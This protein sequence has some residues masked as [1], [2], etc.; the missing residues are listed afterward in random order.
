MSELYWSCSETLEQ[1]SESFR[2]FPS[3]SHCYAGNL[4]VYGQRCN[5]LCDV[6]SHWWS[7]PCSQCLSCFSGECGY[8]TLSLHQGRTGFS[9][10]MHMKCTRCWNSHR[11]MRSEWGQCF[12]W[13]KCMSGWKC[14]RRARWCRLCG[15][16]CN[17]NQ[18]WETGRARAMVLKSTRVIVTQIAQKLK[19]KYGFHKM[20]MRTV[21]G[22]TV[23]IYYIP[24]YCCPCNEHTLNTKLGSSYPPTLYCTSGFFCFSS[25]LGP[26]RRHWEVDIMMMRR[27]RWYM[28][29]FENGQKPFIL[30]PLKSM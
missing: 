9:V 11:F 25:I 7:W 3:G 29:G 15:V 19:L 10:S 12:F 4:F 16:P 6:S 5:W 22:C 23:Y 2:T 17:T 28:T 13:E 14:W 24:S 30:L 26:G 27:R 21:T 20:E 18:W 1:P 8:V